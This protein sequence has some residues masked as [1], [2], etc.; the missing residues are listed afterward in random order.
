MGFNRY[1]YSYGYGY[2]YRPVAG[3]CIRIP[4]FSKYLYSN[5]G[6][7]KWIC[8]CLDLYLFHPAGVCWTPLPKTTQNRTHKAMT[9]VGHGWP[10]GATKQPLWHP[11]APP[12]APK[13]PFFSLCLLDL[14]LLDLYQL[15]TSKCQ[16]L[17]LNTDT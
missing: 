8:I 7:F 6:I 3:I 16:Y 2:G 14:Y 13:W 10:L 4:V 9:H 5:P 12:A 17:D 1:G 11:W 15:D